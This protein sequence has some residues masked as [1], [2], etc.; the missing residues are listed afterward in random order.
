MIVQSFNKCLQVGTFFHNINVLKI[1]TKNKLF[2][3]LKWIY[4]GEIISLDNW[5]HMWL[6]CQVDI[7][8][9]LMDSYIPEQKKKKKQPKIHIPECHWCENL[10]KGP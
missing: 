5:C 7:D 4:M 1:C 9:I 3:E 8:F 2:K 10:A 6:T